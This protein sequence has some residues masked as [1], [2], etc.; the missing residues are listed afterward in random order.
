MHW[1]RSGN[2]GYKLTD[3]SR[4]LGIDLRGNL[5]PSIPGA[6]LQRTPFSSF[7]KTF[8][9]IRARFKNRCLTRRVLAGQQLPKQLVEVVLTSNTRFLLTSYTSVSGT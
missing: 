8:G 2:R 1:L 9:K 6:N 7:A 5:A 3:T 4:A